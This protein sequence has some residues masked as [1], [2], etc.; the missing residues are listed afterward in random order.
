MGRF[1]L[2]TRHLFSDVRV[3]EKWLVDNLTTHLSKQVHIFSNTAV[4]KYCL[5]DFVTS[6]QSNQNQAKPIY[7]KFTINV[8]AQHKPSF[9][10]S[11]Y[12]TLSTSFI[13]TRYRWIHFNWRESPYFFFLIS[14]LIVEVHC[15]FAAIPPAQQLV[16]CHSNCE[17]AQSSAACLCSGC[18]S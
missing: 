1:K 2:L 12:K 18:H 11:S 3:E 6:L 16:C 14:M 9:V 10:V 5:C 8:F 13:P 17:R 7:Q 15:I 4:L